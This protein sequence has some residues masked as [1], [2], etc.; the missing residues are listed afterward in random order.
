[1]FTALWQDLRIG[2]RNL[3]ASPRF[4]L[5]ASLTLALGVGVNGAVFSVVNGTML[6]VVPWDAEDMVLISSQKQGESDGQPV[7]SARYQD[8]RE[9]SQSFREL[10]AVRYRAFVLTEHEPSEAIGGV[11]VSPETFQTIQL[12]MA[13]GRGLGAADAAPDAPPQVV[14]S[15]ALWTERFGAARDLV[16]RTIEIDEQ[17]VAVAGVLA[18]DQWYP[19]PDTQ[20]LA[21]LRLS[22]LQGPRDKGVFQVIGV[23]KPGVTIERARSSSTRSVSGS[24]PSIPTPT[25][26]GARACATCSRSSRAA[27][28]APRCC[29]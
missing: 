2:A 19:S 18:E 17:A 25:R 12:R 28:A 26:A 20:I 11:E 21:P 24:R 27:R 5:V 10:L 6:N 29:S 22:Q 9:Q 7:S 13:L 15:H 14:L 16:G 8:W 3:L 1:M 23:L 4:A